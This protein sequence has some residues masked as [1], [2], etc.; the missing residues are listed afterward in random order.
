MQRACALGTTT[1]PGVGSELGIN[2]GEQAEK[3]GIAQTMESAGSKA[4]RIGC[5]TLA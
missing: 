2:Q 5:G 3:G 4:S 1:L